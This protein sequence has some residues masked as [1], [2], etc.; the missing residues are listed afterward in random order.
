M[1]ADTHPFL[2]SLQEAT[3]S[4]DLRAVVD[5]F[6]PAYRNETPAHPSRD[7]RGQEQVRANWSQIFEFVPDVHSRVQRFAANG[8]QVW[9]EWEMSGTRRDG[10]RHLM[11]GVIIF[12][13][14]DGRAT[15][16]RFY[17]EPV[18][19]TSTTDA[20]AAVRAQVR[21]ETAT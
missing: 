19:E 8:N 15:A 4:H 17:L 7:F 11:R 16:A 18:D 3:N 6:S 2:D 13:V 14:L 20:D 12:T 5:C 10:S 9:S 1:S 21:A